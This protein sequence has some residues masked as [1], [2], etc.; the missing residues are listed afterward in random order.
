MV[1]S[2]RGGGQTPATIGA[3]RASAKSAVSSSEAAAR[4]R[5]PARV[6]PVLAD[7]RGDASDQRQGRSRAKLSSEAELMARSGYTALPPKPLEMLNCVLSLVTGGGR[8]LFRGVEEALSLSRPS[9]Q[10]PENALTKAASD[11]AKL[12]LR[13][14]NG[15]KSGSD[16]GASDVD[17]RG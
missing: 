6:E 1:G 3:R 2:V 5:G 12:A 10:S 8:I 4:P 16:D 15:Y 13:A 17:V 9:D 7:D 14:V 11:R